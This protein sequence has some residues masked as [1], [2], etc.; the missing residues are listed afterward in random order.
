MDASTDENVVY[1][2]HKDDYNVIK[3]TMLFVMEPE[4]QNRF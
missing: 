2:S 1:Q 3:S 4:L